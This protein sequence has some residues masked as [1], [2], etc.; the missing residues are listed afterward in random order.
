MSTFDKN[1]RTIPN[2]HGFMM[3]VLLT[4]YFLIMRFIGLGHDYWLRALNLLIVFF[5]IR[6]AL[7]T[8]R[9][10]SQ[11]SYYEDFTDYFRI[12]ARTSLVGI[13]LFSVFLAIYLDQLDTVF[14]EEIRTQENISPYLTPVSAAFL[15]F[16]EGITSSLA[17]GY[18]LIQVMKSR[19]V[20]KPLE[21]KQELRKEIK[22]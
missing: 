8:Y 21:A 16:V 1:W 12:A 11:A 17:C 19:T 18:I 20:E 5:V 14:M 6:S 2:R 3:F 22:S 15:I 9:S 4:G 10:R 13:A 7:R